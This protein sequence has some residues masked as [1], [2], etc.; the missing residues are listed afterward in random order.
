ML[1]YLGIVIAL[2]MQNNPLTRQLWKL[3]SL[4][5][6]MNTTIDIDKLKFDQLTESKPPRLYQ[7]IMLND[8]FTTMDFVMEVLI[9]IFRKS[10][11]EAE[12][13]MLTI[14]YQGKGICGVY[15]KDIAATRVKQVHQ[16]ARLEQHPL[17]CTMEPA[18]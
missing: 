1:L 17:K 14:H 15:S 12:R 11:E 16:L 13:I 2:I 5:M 4:I 18:P 7:V 8:D 9:D 3:P 6:S 10:A